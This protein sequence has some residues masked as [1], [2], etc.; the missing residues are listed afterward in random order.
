MGSLKVGIRDA[1]GS[2]FDRASVLRQVDR[3]RAR[4]FSKF[5]AFVRTRARSSMRP[6]RQKS[7]SE[8]SREE[9]V[10]YEERVRY[11]EKHGRDKPKRPAASSAPGEAPR[12]QLG[13]LK[14]FLY[15]AYDDES[16]SVVI[17]PAKLNRD[18]EAPLT[19]EEGGSV[20]LWNGRTVTIEARPYMRP[21]FLAE[22]EN[23]P[24]LWAGALDG[25]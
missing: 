7:L 6:A 20:R 1:Q 9:I 10:V 3:A 15:F 21:A 19:L 5:G 24:A 13:F 18:G 11:A 2:F 14:Q 12:V 23:V 17:G 25:V 4:V 8:M 16:K 22:T